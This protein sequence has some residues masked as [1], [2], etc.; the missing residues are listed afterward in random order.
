MCASPGAD[1]R[2]SRRR[3]ARVPA[4][5]W[6]TGAD[7]WPSSNPVCCSL[8]LHC[9]EAALLTALAL[10]TRQ[11]LELE[12]SLHMLKPETP[13]GA[14]GKITLLEA[15]TCAPLGD[16]M[17]FTDL[18]CCTTVQRVA[19]RCCNAVQRVATS[20]A[21][22]VATWARESA[23][24]HDLL[25]CPLDNSHVVHVVHCIVYLVRCRVCAAWEC[26]GEEN[27]HGMRC[28]L[29][30]LRAS[31]HMC[32]HVRA[33]TVFTVAHR[34]ARCSVAG[35]SAACGDHDSALS[36]SLAQSTV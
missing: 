34:L 10:R 5:T 22:H 6:V 7:A 35:A 31:P 28:M 2:E 13:A 26:C 19:T 23:D 20:A 29:G 24:A 3:C 17:I 32:A 18:V 21:K 4:Q 33:L 1:V 9:D 15:S 36:G 11:I 25:C 30:L 8:Q 16:W 14:S 27:L 12:A